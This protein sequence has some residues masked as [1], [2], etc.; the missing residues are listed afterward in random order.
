MTWGQRSVWDMLG[1]KHASELDVFHV[2]LTSLVPEA[3][4]MAEIEGSLSRLLCTYETLRT[5]FR[6][7]PPPLQVLART[8][9]LPL[10]VVKAPPSRIG[11]A[12]ELL[13]A[14]LRGPFEP[15]EMATRASVLCVPGA[16]QELSLVLNH[17]AIDGMSKWILESALASALR[18]DLRDVAPSL[19]HPLDIAEFEQSALARK[20]SARAHEHWRN[21]LRRMPQSMF[22]CP[23]QDGHDHRRAASRQRVGDAEYASRGLR[24]AALRLAERHGA[25]SGTVVLAAASALVSAYTGSHRVV[26]HLFAANRFEPGSDVQ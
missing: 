26:H 11:E 5:S 15:G 17:V 20:R 23:P 22:A 2:E 7:G 16:P 19:G 4:S 24:D 10:H 8:G 6:A 14:R 9:H 18:S 12:R 3:T 25:G 1:R 21:Q 13:A